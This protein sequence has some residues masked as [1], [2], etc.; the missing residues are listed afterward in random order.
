MGRRR[1]EETR[2][3]ILAAALD[4]LTERGY[5]GLTIEGI[6]ARAGSGKQTIYRWW[7]SLADVVL[8]AML[9]RA[10]DLIPDPA[11]GTLAGDL[12]EFVTATF[13]Q[14]PPQ[15]E[16]LSGLMAQAVL[17]PDFAAAFR[18]RFITARRTA[19]RAVLDRAALDPDVDPELLVDVVFGVLWY[20]LLVGHAPL[21]DAEG[22]ALAE[23]VVRA[24]QPGRCSGPNASGST[25]DIG[26]GPRGESTRQS[27]PPN[28]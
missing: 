8:D 16:I 9:E 6:A 20:R 4:E 15:R 17:D 7:P 27:G 21:D 13:R 12:R 14:G 25:S 19:L 28:S 5:A 24:A 22:E 3:A 10:A 26:M 1:S 11:T 23:L 2:H 18:E